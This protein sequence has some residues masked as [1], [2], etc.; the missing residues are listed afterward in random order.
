MNRIRTRL[1]KKSLLAT[2]LLLGG[3]AVFGVGFLFG[4][5]RAER[6]GYHRQYL[7]ERQ[8]IAPLLARDAAFAG[9]DIHERSDGGVY[10]LGEVQTAADRNRLRDVVSLEIARR[11]AR[12]IGLAVSVAR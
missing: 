10:L 6:D 5:F 8:L 2:M 3:A 1:W 12:E 9:L 11:R 7:E 4:A